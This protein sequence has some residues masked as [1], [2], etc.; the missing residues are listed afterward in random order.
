VAEPRKKAYANLYRNYD[1]MK[2]SVKMKK[3]GV[4]GIQS[5]FEM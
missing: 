3:D 2:D 5:D 4:F 1:S